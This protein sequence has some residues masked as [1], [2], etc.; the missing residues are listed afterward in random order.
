MNPEQP[1]HHRNELTVVNAR[2]IEDA[3]RITETKAII[4]GANEQIEAL[5]QELLESARHVG[6]ADVAVSILHN[7]GNVLNS[8]NVSII[9]LNENK[10]KT[11]F[12]RLLEVCRMLEENSS[13]INQYL[14]TDD[15]GKLIPEYLAHLSSSL[16]KDSEIENREL[17]NLTEKIPDI[18]GRV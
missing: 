11:H 18:K 8:A 12:K 9:L 16:V 10:E 13:R 4:A 17:E 6:M 15:K 14:T 2:I 5:N 3:V 1:K 7:V